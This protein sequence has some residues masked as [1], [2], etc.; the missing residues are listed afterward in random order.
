MKTQPVDNTTINARIVLERTFNSRPSIE[1]NIAFEYNLAQQLGRLL[2]KNGYILDDKS[3]NVLKIQVN[4]D[5]K[6]SYVASFISGLSLYLIPSYARDIYTMQATYKTTK[7]TKT[8]KIQ[9]TV[10]TW[11]HLTMLF[12]APFASGKTAESE[13]IQNMFSKIIHDLN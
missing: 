11:N 4:V 1:N 5:S 3:E 9:D 2:E 6:V 7:T 10:Y 8:I 12:I 13:T